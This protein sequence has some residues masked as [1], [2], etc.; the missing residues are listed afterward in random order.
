[1]D[2]IQWIAERIHENLISSPWMVESLLH[3]LI[4]HHAFFSTKATSTESRVQ[5]K[6]HPGI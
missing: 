3:S 5:L 6:E 1:M 2:S 4:H